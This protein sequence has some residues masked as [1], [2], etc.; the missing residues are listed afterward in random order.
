MADEE[1]TCRAISDYYKSVTDELDLKEGQQYTIMQTSPSGWW[2]AVNADS[3][4]GWVP[5]TYLERIDAGSSQRPQHSY[6]KKYNSVE[7]DD[8]DICFDHFPSRLIR[9]LS[10]NSKLVYNQ[11]TIDKKDDLLIHG[12]FR[13]CNITTQPLS[14]DVN[15][16][17]A[18]YY[19]KNKSK[20]FLQRKIS[21]LQK[22]SISRRKKQIKTCKQCIFWFLIFLILVAFAFS[23][24][25]V[26]LITVKKYDCDMGL[27]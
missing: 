2:Y 9:Q 6:I 5:S 11:W 24:D 15:R 22:E 14:I 21:D 8:N 7:M 23:I 17:I 12:Y 10:P 16:I 3:E 20:G 25:V 1:F 18:S 19:I 26:A 4:D 13:E 27:N